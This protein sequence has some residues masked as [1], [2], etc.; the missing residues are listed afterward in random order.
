[1]HGVDWGAMRERYAGML[2]DCYTR[3]EVAYVIRE[4][5]S[6]L[7]VGHAYYN[8]G[9]DED[10]PRSPVGLLGCDFA[11]DQGSYKIARIYGGAAWDAD[12]RGP[13]RDPGLDVHEGDFVLAV[14]GRALDPAQDPWAAFDGL[15]GKTV[16]LTVSARPARDEIARDVV[17]K[18]IEDDAELRY[19]WWVEQNRLAVERKTDGQVGYIHVPDTGVR[20]QNELVR[21]FFSQVDRPALIIDERWNGGGQVPTRFIELLNRP[22]TNLWTQRDS[23]PLVW[24]PDSH[25]GPKCMLINMRAGS[26]GDAFP[27]YFRAAK[28]GK[29]IGTRT[30][31]GLI[32]IGDLP[33]MLDGASVSVP[34][35]AFYENDGTW[36]VEGHGVEPDIEVIDDPALMTDGGDPQL[37]KAIEVMLD[38]LQEKPYRMPPAPAYPDR[39]GMGIT[40]EDR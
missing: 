6:E 21:Q 1:M 4:L 13:L 32:G 34:N 26:G 5:I 39:S 30:W 29:L 18:P 14:N 24:P 11:L 33:P 7:N 12:A 35:F 17:V 27:Y 9:P 40:A 37:D 20:G 31:G 15:S 22:A 38:E 28:L 36:G 23:L 8:P 10:V 3:Y 19:R 25:Q 16:T 2:D